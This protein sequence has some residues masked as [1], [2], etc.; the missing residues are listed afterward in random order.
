MCVDSQTENWEMMQVWLRNISEYCLMELLV[1]TAILLCAM[2]F[3]EEPV[4]NSRDFVLAEPAETE[5]PTSH[6]NGYYLHLHSSHVEQ[7]FS[8][9]NEN[10][11]HE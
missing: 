10:R 5:K 11:T 3:E 2:H 8:K 6:V 4:S 9:Q 1:R 7:H